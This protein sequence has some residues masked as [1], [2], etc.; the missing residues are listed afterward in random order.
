MN[1]KNAR[2]VL[3]N[4]TDDILET[5]DD[6]GCDDA[7]EKDDNEDE[8]RVPTCCS[9]NTRRGGHPRI[10]WVTC[11]RSSIPLS[12]AFPNLMIVDLAPDFL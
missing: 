2:I 9:R 8:G 1:E 7:E 6:N 3:D 4:T 5:R 11:F 12:I 10:P